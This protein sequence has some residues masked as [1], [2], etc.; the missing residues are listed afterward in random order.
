ME[1]LTSLSAIVLWFPFL[2]LVAVCGVSFA[3]LGY[4][5]GSIRAAISLAVTALSTFLSVVL[6]RALA[7]IPSGKFSSLIEKLLAT[8]LPA[9]L[10]SPEFFGSFAEGVMTATFAVMLFV[11]LFLL[12]AGLIK[13]LSSYF[14]G[15][16]FKAP[17]KK[18]DRIGGL[19]ISIVD[20]VVVALVLLLPLYAPIGTLGSLGAVLPQEG[21]T[22]AI[23]ETVDSITDVLPVKIASLPPFSTAYHALTTI[24]VDGADLSI[25]STL[26]SASKLASAVLELTSKEEGDKSEALK[27]IFEEGET[28][29][30]ENEFVFDALYQV[31]KAAELPEDEK[32]SFLKDY[33]GFENKETLRADLKAVFRFLGNAI[34]AGVE[35]VIG[36]DSDWSKVDRDVLAAELG[37]LLN[38]TD[39]LAAL[40]AGGIETLLDTFLK[41]SGEEEGGEVD[42][43]SSSTPEDTVNEALAP[44]LDAFKNIPETPY[45]EADALKEGQAIVQLVEGALTL[46]TTKDTGA[47]VG[48]LLEGL[49]RHPAVGTETLLEVVEPLLDTV[50]MEA[51][52]A[53][54]DKI[55]EKLTES[56]D[57][58]LSESTFVGF[59]SV[60][61]STAGALSDILNPD[62]DEEGNPA[63]PSSENIKNLL[64][65]DA[66][67]IAELRELLDDEF[68]DSIG[69]PAEAKPIEEL[70]DKLLGAIENN[71]FTEE[72]AEREAEALSSVLGVFYGAMSNGT[73]P[74][75]DELISY[76]VDSELLGKIVG[77][78][79]NGTTSDPLGLFGAMDGETKSTLAG[80]IDTYKGTLTVDQSAVSQ[81]LDHLK[82][83]LGV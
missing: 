75:P 38:A 52:E 67:A 80:W 70:L 69:I 57:K 72:E 10:L 12:I 31:V 51:S 66:G 50:G 44:L 60:T 30:F 26:D 15:K 5:R 34:D 71:T 4:Q 49:A 58:P 43:P 14:L 29:I 45:G 56:V 18:G 35:N 1:L 25:S 83:F 79:L 27:V 81:K 7:G 40:K 22:V 24:E 48:R 36:E 33:T 82:L 46:G 2:A 76:Y 11:P 63:P 19:A 16:V 61:I 74:D 32:L 68:L 59:V 23:V 54:L 21:P 6:A 55:E 42:P 53:L 64:S 9:G 37:K 8:V 3:L 77:D 62:T 65:A 39:T 17:E 13:I 78:S 47:G 41:D 20:A 28:L 73:I